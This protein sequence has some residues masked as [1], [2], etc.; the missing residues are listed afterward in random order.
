MLDGNGETQTTNETLAD[1]LYK[2]SIE[3]IDPSKKAEDVDWEKFSALS[4]AI[5][6]VDYGV[7]P[8]GDWGVFKDGVKGFYLENRVS[9][10]LFYVKGDVSGC[11]DG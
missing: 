3:E 9:G 11:F 10:R 8:E 1:I 4:Q 5:H 2:Q 7:Y 6:F